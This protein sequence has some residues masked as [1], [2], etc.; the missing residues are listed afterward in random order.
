MDAIPLEF[1]MKSIS[2]FNAETFSN[3]SLIS[4]GILQCLLFLLVFWHYHNNVFRHSGS[5]KFRFFGQ[6]SPFFSIFLRI[7][8]ELLRSIV[9][10]YYFSIKW[11]YFLIFWENAK[12]QN[13]GPQGPAKLGNIVAKILLRRQ[14]FPSL[15][16]TSW[17]AQ[18]TLSCRQKLRAIY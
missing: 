17:A 11:R 16:M 15:A 5:T 4:A 12:M 13:G 10:L 3:C 6:N 7:I 1:F 9:L 2:F 14:M 8:A 18:N